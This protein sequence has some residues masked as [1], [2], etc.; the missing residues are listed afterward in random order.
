MAL[1]FVYGSLREGGSAHGLLAEA[2]RG[3]DGSL[4]DVRL[5]EHQGYL[6]LVPG[7]DT[8]VGQVYALPQHHSWESLDDWEE[9]P[10]VYQRVQRQLIDGREVWVYI[11]SAVKPVG[12]ADSA[13]GQS[14]SSESPVFAS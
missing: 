8:V 9:A 6:M 13:A 3:R 12:A 5:I 4:P 7:S 14:R 2:R 10:A 11:Q 1:L